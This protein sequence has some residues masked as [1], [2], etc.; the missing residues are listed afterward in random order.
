MNTKIK[1]AMVCGLIAASV[2]TPL[3]VVSAGETPGFKGAWEAI[4]VDESQEKM[5]IRGGR[6][7]Q[8]RVLLRDSWFSGEGLD[9]PGIA[10]GIGT[11][12][13]GNENKLNAP[14]TPGIVQIGEFDYLFLFFPP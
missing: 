5:T 2:L 7:G 3:S 14:L 10:F 11:V 4:D 13:E 8:Y 12:D 9:C 1:A 6:D